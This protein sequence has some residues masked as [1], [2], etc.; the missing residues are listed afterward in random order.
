MSGET[1]WEKTNNEGASCLS[2][3]DTLIADERARL[4]QDAGLS[5]APVRHFRRLVE[6]PFTREERDRVTILLGGLSH[7]HDHLMR[8]ALEGLGYRAALIPVSTKADFQTGKEYGNNG[9]CN[10]TYFTVGALVNYL[11]RLRDEQGIPTEKILSDYVFATGGACGPCRF[12]MY[13]AEYRLALRNAGFEGFRVIVFEQEGGLA[14]SNSDAGL[15]MNVG[16]FL[17]LLNA[18]FMG[19]LLNAMAFHV[20][21]YETEPGKTDAVLQKCLA[22]CEE[23]LRTKRTSRLWGARLTQAL[24]K[25]MPSASDKVALFLD[26]LWGAHYVAALENCRK[27]IQEEIEVD[28]TR[29]KPIVKITGEFWAQT[30]EGDGNFH[31]FRFLENEGAEILVEP[32]ATWL[33]Y[34]LKYWRQYYHDRRGLAEHEGPLNLWDLG[35]RIQREAYYRK[36]DLTFALTSKLL[37]REYDRMRRA[38]GGTAHPLADQFELQRVGHPYYHS[39]CGGGEAY[40]EIAKN[41]YYGNRDLAHMVLSLKPFGC[42]PSTQSDGAQAAVLS[43]Y[44]DLIFLPIETSGEGDINA[45]SR[46]QMALGDA[47]L[48]CKNEFR[49]ILDGSGYSLD[50]IR[51]YVAGHRELRRPL[52]RIPH[53]RGVVGRAANF[54]LHV[55]SKMDRDAEWAARKRRAPQ[56]T[57]K[58]STHSVPL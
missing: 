25:I 13:E 22:L 7:R 37:D 47:K 15:E 57:S 18:V 58:T 3:L 41:I 39:R 10:P 17:A 56:K 34:S 36:K 14:Q 6:H 32:V 40:L 1:T 19:D 38:L 21:P 33:D 24:S 11:K 20:R 29:S 23:A 31:M 42:M 48:K 46:T 51:A 2:S 50:D 26:Q 35:R 5:A 44:P 43:H 27:V 16:F 4:L 12:G 45:Y 55:A 30:T 28:Y 52:Q 9:Q 49:E 8:A 53:R 54:V